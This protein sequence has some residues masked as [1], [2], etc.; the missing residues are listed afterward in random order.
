MS[1]PIYEK[2]STALLFVDPY[3]D[4]LSEGGKVWPRVKAVAE[5]V[6]LI[7]TLKMINQAVRSAGLNVLI[8][9]HSRWKPGDYESW[10]HPNPMWPG[11]AM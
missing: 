7:A 2:R 3:N 10:C 8:V 11:C 9:P 6:G 1:Q 5:E 4:F